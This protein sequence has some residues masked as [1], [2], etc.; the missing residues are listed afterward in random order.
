[1]VVFICAGE[2][3]CFF[4]IKVN[5]SGF[6]EDRP[7]RVYIRGAI[8][9]FDFIE[10]VFATLV[11]VQEMVARLK[12]LQ[13]L[14]LY[15]LKV[16]FSLDCGLRPLTNKGVKDMVNSLFPGRRIAELFLLAPNDDCPSEREDEIDDNE[17]QR[18]GWQN[19]YTDDEDESDQSYKE[20]VRGSDYEDTDED[21]RM[22]EKNID[23]EVDASGLSKLKNTYGKYKGKNVAGNQEE[24]SNDDDENDTDVDQYSNSYLESLSSDDEEVNGTKKQKWPEFNPEIDMDDP[25][26]S[27]GM[28][29]PSRDVL[30]MAIRMH[31]IKER[32]GVKFLKD[33]FTRVRAYCPVACNWLCFA[34]KYRYGDCQTFQIRTYSPVHTCSKIWNNRLCNANIVFDWYMDDFRSNPNMTLSHLMFRVQK[35][36]NLKIS[37]SQAFWAKTKALEKVRGKVAQQYAQLQDYIAEIL[38]TNPG[39][40][41]V[42]KTEDDDPERFQRLYMCFEVTKKG[43]IEGSQKLIGMDGC[44]LKGPGGGQL[45]TAIG[46]DA[47]NGFYLVAYAVVKIENKDSWSW[48]LRL[49]VRDIRIIDDNEWVIITDKQKVK[50][51]SYPET[52]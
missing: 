21:D 27:K 31:G 15:Y 5:H 36:K 4:C 37:K 19:A 1:M 33:D 50:Y 39:S 16:G 25:K 9:Y 40:T 22:Y 46:I 44:H 34:S 17:E 20:S 8:D 49:L 2:K 18:G 51:R 29:F 26:F 28:L 45:L 7:R 43:F 11:E 24:N 14:K 13:S 32:K 35:E 38:R 10:L 41:V 47:N 23:L 6:F 30:K 42:L 12:Y 3:A 52:Y 48:F